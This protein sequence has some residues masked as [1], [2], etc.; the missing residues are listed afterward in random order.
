MTVSAEVH[1]MDMTDG[2]WADNRGGDWLIKHRLRAAREGDG[3]L[4]SLCGDVSVG[5]WVLAPDP[6]VGL[7]C[8]ECEVRAKARSQAG[9]AHRE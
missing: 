5:Q 6:R 3:R 7:F 4:R 2:W 8:L 9:V 1:G